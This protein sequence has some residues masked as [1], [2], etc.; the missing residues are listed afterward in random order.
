MLPL[1]NDVEAIAPAHPST[2][3]HPIDVRNGLRVVMLFRLT[4]DIA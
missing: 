4:A 2:V 3:S 1:K